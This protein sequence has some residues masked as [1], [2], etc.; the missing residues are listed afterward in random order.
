M[1]DILEFRAA[2][3]RVWRGVIPRARPLAAVAASIKGPPGTGLGGVDYVE[4]V[5]ESD[6]QQ[7]GCCVVES[8]CNKI[9]GEMRRARGGAVLP[10]GAVLDADGM[11]WQ[12]R[13]AYYDDERDDGLE[14]PQGLL[15]LHE[16]I[17]LLRVKPDLVEIGC[18][19]SA[20]HAALAEQMLTAAFL[21]GDNWARTSVSPHNGIIPYRALNPFASWGGH[22][23][24]MIGYH[25]QDNTHL[26]LLQNSWPDWGYGGGIGA[27]EWRTLVECWRWMQEPFLSISNLS[28]VVAGVDPDVLAQWT[29]AGPA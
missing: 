14:L 16:V 22:A 24:N 8:A 13:R 28:A 21:V 23:V 26:F 10:P 9:L 4:A 6:Q 12:I 29:V 25:Y 2:G 27:L 19:A 17:G 15:G 11:Y 18:D 20:L 7:A 3:P 1:R 5:Q